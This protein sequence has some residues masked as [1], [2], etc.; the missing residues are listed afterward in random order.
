M[1]LDDTQEYDEVW[2]IVFKRLKFNPFSNDKGN[3]AT[4]IL[5]FEIDGSY[6]VYTIRDMPE[7]KL[8]LMGKL[9]RNSL[10]RCTAKG[11]K[12]YALGWQHSAFKFDP[13]N[14]EEQQSFWKEDERYI[15]AVDITPIFHPFIPTA[16]IISL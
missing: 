13:Q 11:K 3:S 7:E 5:P 10:V 15:W 9:V 2:N 8:D 14:M 6:S 4:A 16:I 12:W 1:L